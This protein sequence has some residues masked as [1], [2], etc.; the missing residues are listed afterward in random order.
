MNIKRAFL[1]ATAALM[2]P[3]F[4]MA[5]VT[6]TVDTGIV[7]ANGSSAGSAIATLICNGGEE[8][9]QS[10]PVGPTAGDRVNFVNP[11]VT[12]PLADDF[13]CEVTFNDIPAGYDIGFV[14]VNGVD[15]DLNDS[16]Y[17]GLDHAEP[18][19]GM[20]CT[21][22]LVAEDFTLLV[23]V[24]WNDNGEDTT[25]GTVVAACENV[26]DFYGDLVDWEGSA[27][28]CSNDSSDLIEFTPGAPV[29]RQAVTV[30]TV[31]MIG[32]DSSVESEGCDNPIV[33]R[34][35]DA[36]KGCT[37]T[38]TVFFEGIP[39]LSQYGMAIM[40]LL[41]LGLGFVGFRRFI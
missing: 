22:V 33:F 10:F 1:A 13:W 17:W 23:E 11:G 40:A 5:Q 32:L 7:F 36:P 27:V 8:L 9:I 15:E 28:S 20:E 6:I 34:V 19:I 21:A 2:L 25:C 26:I 24:N 4:A 38:N 29:F 30:C 18:G 41:M 16:C 14:Q 39:T 31:G 35:G 3:G 12:D 37:F